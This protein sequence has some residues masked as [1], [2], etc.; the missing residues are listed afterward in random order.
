M[1]LV[2]LVLLF[3]LG[4]SL[5][6]IAASTRD[7]KIAA[8]PSLQEVVSA[9]KDV[10]G[11]LAMAQSNGPSYEFFEKLLPP[12]RYVNADFY[13]YPIVL[14]APNTKVK[15]RLISNGSGVNLRA[16]AGQWNDNGVPVLFRVG[17]DQLSFG[18][19]PERLQ[20]E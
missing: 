10:W 18:R 4:F 14:S 12:P 11:E 13:F 19:F 15:A 9:R 7:A 6:A 20:Q 1:R 17:P 3:A 2:R 8:I 16:G 5:P